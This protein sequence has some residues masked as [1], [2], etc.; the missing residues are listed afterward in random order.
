MSY[1][2]WLEAHGGLD[3]QCEQDDES[4]A[5]DRGLCFVCREIDHIDNLQRMTGGWLAHEGCAATYATVKP[6]EQR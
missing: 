3:P 1:F 4:E 5:L 6:K 2:D